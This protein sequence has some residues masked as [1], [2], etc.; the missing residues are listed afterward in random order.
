MQLYFWYTVSEF[1]RSK[2]R[3]AVI[4]MFKNNSS[5]EYSMPVFPTLL[6]MLDLLAVQM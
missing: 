3:F 5:A 1:L 4:L 6:H 2:C